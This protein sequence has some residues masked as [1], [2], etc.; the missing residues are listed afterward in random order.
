MRP[1]FHPRLINGPND[2]PGL[3]VPFLFENRAII[4]DLGDTHPL[5]TR[6][7]LK[8]SHAFITHTHIDHF[9]GFDR[10]LRIFL[11]REKNL[12]LYGPQGFLKNVEGKLAAYAW[13]LVKNYKYKLGLHLTEVHRDYL[14][15]REYLCQNEFVPIHDAV[16]HA[17]N[18]VLYE[19]PAFRVSAAILDHSIP[20]LGFAIKER[21]HVN[22]NRDRIAALELH[23]GP[24]LTEFKQALYDGKDAKSKFEVKSGKEKIHRFRLGELA[25]QIAMITPGQ[26]IT[27]IADVVYNSINKNKIVSLAKDSDHL[28]IEAAFLEAHKDIAAEKNHLT[29]R[30]AGAL[31]AIARVKQFTIFHF[32]PRYTDQAHLLQEEARK[33][34]ESI[35]SPSMEQS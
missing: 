33:A 23:T 9:I 31:A 11:G 8:I 14:L 22:I 2:D 6:D 3:Y 32:S 18:E 4:F 21:F 12:H 13:N 1:R 34:Y 10:I 24:W 29:A 15:T 17:F 30:Q 7:L 27:Y 20:C 35:M 16:K 28:F 5:S 26:K 25:D 19:E